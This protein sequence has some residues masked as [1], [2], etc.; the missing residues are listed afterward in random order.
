M[1]LQE[2]V[3][4]MARPDIEEGH[5]VV[6]EPQHTVG[7]VQFIQSLGGHVIGIDADIHTRYERIHARGSAK[8]QVTFEEFRDFEQMESQSDDPN[9]NNLIAAGREAAIH[10]T[11]NGTLEELHTQIDE[12]L[13]KLRS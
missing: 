13:E 7:E 3:Y 8:D 12:A 10:V 11:N 2:A 6:I 5:D 9:R 1:K 4:E